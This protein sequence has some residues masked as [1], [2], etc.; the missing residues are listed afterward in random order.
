MYDLFLRF[1]YD[2]G[3][4]E[5]L[6]ICM[7]LPLFK[8]KGLRTYDKDNYKGITMFPVITKIFEMILLKRLEDFSRSKSYF[9]PFQVGFKNFVG[10]LE[11]SFVINESVNYKLER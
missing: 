9:S 1:F 6:K 5:M 4:P 8:G 7:M 11:A 10:C 3:S 2:N